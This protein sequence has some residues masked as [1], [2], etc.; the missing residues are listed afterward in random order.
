MIQSLTSA[1]ITSH[2]LHTVQ[3]I[4]VQRRKTFICN[5][6]WNAMNVGED[7]TRAA[8][9]YSLRGGRKESGEKNTIQSTLSL[10]NASSL[11]LSLCHSSTSCIAIQ[12]NMKQTVQLASLPS[13]WCGSKNHCYFSWHTIMK[14][15]CRHPLS[16]L[17]C[18]LLIFLFILY[19]SVT[20]WQS[21]SACCQP[22][23]V[24][25][26]PWPPPDGCK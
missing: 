20:V 2:V 3:T 6:I 25:P 12:I 24:W 10:I 14:V 4:S 5:L 16:V 17:A 13:Q 11:S 8:P 22:S 1:Y 15:V 7:W 23:G 26:S 18:Q 19:D 21:H 9:Q